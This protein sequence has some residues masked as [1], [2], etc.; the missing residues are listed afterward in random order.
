VSGYLVKF[1]KDR[2]ILRSHS[3]VRDIK[4]NTLWELMAPMGDMYSMDKKFIEH[5]PKIKGYNLVAT[6]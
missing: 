1:E 6:P 4:T 5:S 2:A 3:V